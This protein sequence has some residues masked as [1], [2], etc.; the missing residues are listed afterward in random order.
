MA[1]KTLKFVVKLGTSSLTKGTQNLSRRHMLEYVRQIA[2]L[3]EDGHQIVIVSS[4]AVAAGREILKHPKVDRSL[5]SKQMFA[6]V[7]Q[8]RLMQIWAELFALYDISVGQLLLTRD[9]FSHRQRYL[10][11]RD[12][13]ASLLYQQVIPIINENDSVATRFNKVGDNDNLS[14]L[15]ANL[16]AA[17]KLILLTDQ[18]G[19]YTADPRQNIDAKLLPIVNHIDDSILALAGGASLG[20]GGTGGFVTKIEAAKLA[21]QSGTSTVIAASYVPNVLIDL[22]QGKSIGTIFLAETTPRESRKRWLLSEKVQ[23]SIQVDDGAENGLKEK[24]ASLLPIGI[25]KVIDSFDRGA[26]VKIISS[27]GLPIAV[28]IANYSSKDIQT[29]AGVHSKQIEDF[30]GY[31]YGQVVIHRDNLILQRG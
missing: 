30:L 5:P 8:G 3:H 22:A 23:G 9:D 20:G 15:A 10:N 12:T 13:L 24:G 29:L 6:A 27:K 1:K 11:V 25:V 21:V 14:A 16:I 19:L 7:G 26:I 18:E 31:S 28:G 17:D 2:S 4:G